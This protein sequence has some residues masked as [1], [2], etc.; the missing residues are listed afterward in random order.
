MPS[1]GRY[2]VEIR[3][4]GV[5]TACLHALLP[6]PKRCVER[7]PMTL[8]TICTIGIAII[9]DTAL[10]WAAQRGH[11]KIPPEHESGPGRASR[12]LWSLKSCGMGGTDGL[13]RRDA[14]NWGPRNAVH[15][16]WWSS[17]VWPA[18]TLRA[19][20]ATEVERSPCCC[21]ADDLDGPIETRCSRMEFA[22][23]VFEASGA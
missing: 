8:R 15:L 20:C 5:V 23:P 10:T 21:R 4:W 7:V 13:V 2:L 22:R 18:F 19:R 1:R 9:V 17:R 3:E 6:A 11:T 12:R 16:M 14:R